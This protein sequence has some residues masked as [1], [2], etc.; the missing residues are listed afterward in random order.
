MENTEFKKV[1]I[2]KNATSETSKRKTKFNH[3]INV[4]VYNN[5]ALFKGDTYSY[6]GTF[7]RCGGEFNK[8][9]Y[10]Y[11]IPL[12]RMAECKLQ[13]SNF[14]ESLLVYKKD[15][16]L[17]IGSVQNN[18]IDNELDNYNNEDSSLNSD[19]IMDI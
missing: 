1:A 9:Y 11:L 10:G 14:V 17:D 4:F 7:K 6:R 15:E 19:V 13:I 16:N 5:I 2:K 12:D 18:M 8:K 3:L